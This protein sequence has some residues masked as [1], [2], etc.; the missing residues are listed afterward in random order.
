M[1]FKE[2][3]RPQGKVFL[4]TLQA[5]SAAEKGAVLVNRPFLVAQER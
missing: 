2:M 5:G 3:V 1:A 4:G